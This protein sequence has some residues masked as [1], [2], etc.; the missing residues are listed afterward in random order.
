MIEAKNKKSSDKTGNAVISPFTVKRLH[1]P[2]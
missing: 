1:K 2:S